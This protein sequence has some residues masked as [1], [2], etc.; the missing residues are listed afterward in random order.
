MPLAWPDLIS[1]ARGGEALF[2]L[3]LLLGRYRLIRPMTRT[4]SCPASV[5]FG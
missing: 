5:L 1:I 2:L 3:V 4:S